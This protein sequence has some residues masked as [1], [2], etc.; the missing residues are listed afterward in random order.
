MKTPSQAN[1]NVQLA[2]GS[3]ILAL[4]LVGA[5]SYRGMAI[6]ASSER[7]VRHSH[8]VLETLQDLRFAMES[9]HSNCRGFVLSGNESF[10][11]AYQS[12]SL[13]ITQDQSMMRTLTAANP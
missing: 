2:F 1:R 6:S 7:W 9:L 11:R 4:L 5:V 12:S 13:R 10:V 3:A 8:Q